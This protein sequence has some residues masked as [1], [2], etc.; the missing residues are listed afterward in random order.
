MGLNN[1][2]SPLSEF[3][4]WMH[5]HGVSLFLCNNFDPFLSEQASDYWKVR[6]WLCGFSGS[7]GLFA[8]GLEGAALWSDSRYVLQAEKELHGKGIDF[9]NESVSSSPTL[10]EWISG[11]G[12]PSKS[13]IALDGRCFSCSFISSLASF[14]NDHHFSLDIE[15]RPSE[16]LWVNRPPL[17]FNSIY[18]LPLDATGKSVIDKLRSVRF[19]MQK[20]GAN[21]IVITALDEIAWCFNLRGSDS[22]FSPVANACAYISLDQAYLFIK[23]T[24]MTAELL[25]ALHCAGVIV[26]DFDNWESFL[27]SID[28]NAVLWIDPFKCNAF[29]N[30]LIFS[31]NKIYASSP[32]ELLKSTK[33]QTEIKCEREVMPY[34]GAALCRLF[35]WIEQQ[36]ANNIPLYESQ[37][38]DQIVKIRKGY[39]HYIGESFSAIVG[40][41]ANGAIVHYHPEKGT[42]AI[43]KRD[44]LLLIDTGAHYFYGTTDITRTVALGSPSD[45]MRR[46]FTLVLKGHIALASAVFP[47]GTRGA[48]LDIL[49]RQFLWKE[50]LSYLHGTGHGIGYLL[51]VHEGPQNI[52]L[53]ENP[54]A[55]CPGM[56]LSNEP[57]YYRSGFYGIR[58]ENSV[59]VK[60]YQTTDSGSF[61]CFETLSLCPFDLKLI[62]RSLLSTD[63][64]RW[65]N[66]Y[67]YSVFKAI[68]PLLKGDE[69][70]WLQYNTRPIA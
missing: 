15:S 40:Y 51:N 45:R 52:R 16:L 25:E 13:V 64:I 28:L 24:K 26:S 6:E 12:L 49:A 43:L 66:D 2:F 22:P 67:H 62:D 29:F 47:E 37:V 27:S 21:G 1:K 68:S 58:C 32:I 69:L 50:G 14:C 30:S 56:L 17:C 57:G 10:L 63:E 20:K 19:E 59:L 3:R 9:F 18:S 53:E 36:L 48:Q 44:S 65:L 8:L 4:V 39:S 41:G 54:T 35:F 34:E 70:D 38:A 31:K 23:M 5:G 60:D 61:L 46:D 55:L 7:N 33:N 42:D 11:L